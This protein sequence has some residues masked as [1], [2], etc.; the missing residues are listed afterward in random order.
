[1]AVGLIG[2]GLTLATMFGRGMILD[3]VE[4]AHAAWLLAHGYLPYRD[5]WDDHPPLHWLLM[6]PL[7]RWL[8][9]GVYL[10]DLVRVLAVLV[11]AVGAGLALFLAARVWREREVV[12]VAGLLLIGEIVFLDFFLLRGDLFANAATLAALCLLA[13]RRDA[14][15][16][17]GSGLLLGLAISF[18][19]RHWV[20]LLLVPLFLWWAREHYRGALRLALWHFLGVALGLA[21]L[22]AWLA[23]KGLVAQCLFW[24]LRFHAGM[25][26]EIGGKFPLIVSALA[27]WGIVLLLRSDPWRQ[28]PTGKLLVLALGLGALGYLTQPN[29]KFTYGEQMFGLLAA[30]IAAGPAYTAVRQLVARRH[31]VLVCV[32]V[33]IY[34][35][36]MIY[37]AQQWQRSGNYRQDRRQ[38]RLLLEVARGEPVVCM[39]RVCPEFSG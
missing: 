25:G 38:H 28:D 37:W 10:H 6:Y 5:F 9:V 35:W 2:L 33:G 17:G 18:T 27:V 23:S 12:L 3:E 36:P 15:G 11:S 1:V 21:P 31:T 7:M 4:H 13:T 16:F 30:V 20:Y 24:V 26:S 39:Y 14:V 34:L 19:P 32:M 8:P 29:G 22:A